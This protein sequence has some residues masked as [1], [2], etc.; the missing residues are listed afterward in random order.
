MSN[1]GEFRRAASAWPAAAPGCLDASR[2]MAWIMNSTLGCGRA[3]IEQPTSSR[4]PDRSA[5]IGIVRSSNTKTRMGL[6]WAWRMPSS[7]R[8]CLR[9]L[10]RTTA[11]TS[12][13]YLDRREPQGQEGSTGST[14]VPTTSTRRQDGPSGGCRA[15]T[16]AGY[17]A[18]MRVGRAAV[19]AGAGACLVLAGSFLSWFRSGSRTRSSYELFAVVGRIGAI[20]GPVAAVGISLWV[21]VPVVTAALVA[22]LLLRRMILAALVAC[23]LGLYA[24]ALALTV[25]SSANSWEAGV[26][27]AALGG[28]ACL[29]GGG[30]IL[31]TSRHMKAEPT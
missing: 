2:H 6:R 13:T 24:L 30:A 10:A 29:M 22:A 20:P 17:R 26:I 18:G 3:D 9:A 31:I 15:P 16:H 27:T 28:L 23:G 11:S 25:G 14:P 8:P 1:P 19:V 4:R 7:L 12:S 5:P 21:T